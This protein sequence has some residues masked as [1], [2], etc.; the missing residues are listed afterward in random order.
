MA[1]NLS[2][3]ES[4]QTEFDEDVKEKYAEKRRE[5]IRELDICDKIF[6]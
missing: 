6:L 4:E 2:A 3:L 5:M 1:S